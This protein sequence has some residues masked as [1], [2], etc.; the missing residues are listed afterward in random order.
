MPDVLIFEDDPTVGDL[1]SDVL[2]YK[3]L[4]VEHH[5]SGAGV[6]HR[7]QEARPKLVI[8]DIMMPGMDGLSAC[9]AIR[10]DPTTRD[11]KIVMLTAKNSKQDR[12]TAKRVGADLYLNKPFDSGVFARDVG[13]LLGFP[14]DPDLALVP[15]PPAPPVAVTRLEGGVV[16]Q[17]A[18]MWI[19]FDAG[20]GMRDW[21]YA[22]AHPPKEAWLLL[23]RY[24]EDAVCEINAGG[25]LLVSGT[26]VKIGGPD[27]PDNSLQRV[28]PKLSAGLPTGGRTPLIYPQRE[29]EFTLGPAI[30]AV[31]RYAQHP[32]TTLAYR[33]ELQGRRVVVCPAH[34]IHSD[35]KGWSSHETGKFR[36]LFSAADL[37]PHS[38]RRSLADPRPDD[39]RGSGAWEPVLDLAVEARVKHL[40]LFP[41]PA[42]EIRPGLQAKAQE[43]AVR[44]GSGLRVTVAESAQR[45]VL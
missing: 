26:R 44:K 24:H 40:V 32:G 35:P 6:L 5:L 2:R 29:T 30:T 12:D 22:Q 38:F 10:S 7:V 36:E 39:D 1:A 13:A 31:T 43:R 20:K 41:L 8:L 37:L 18:L 25:V 28:A 21:V 19:L 3:G 33:V 4:T 45:F 11:I 16:L 15:K 42:S 34:E 17:T 23:S 14:R 9:R 27:D